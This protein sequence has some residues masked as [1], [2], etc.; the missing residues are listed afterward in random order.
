MFVNKSEQRNNLMDEGLKVEGKFTTVAKQ[1]KQAIILAGGLGT[2]LREAVPDLPKAMAPVAGRPFLS[3]VID[4]LR[5]QGIEQFIFSLGYKAGIVKKYLEEHYPTLDYSI[6]VEEEPFGTG[7]AIQLACSKTHDVNV[8]VANG[9]TLFK[10][11]LQELENFHIHHQA[12]CTIGLKPLEKFDRYGVVQ[13]NQEG[14]VI[15][16]KE[17]P[18]LR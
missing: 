13:I 4:A 9:D 6:V 15:A 14:S 12:E 10:I 3:F 11:K 8:L 2:R 7:G 16:F 5:M 18:V 17:K 1:I